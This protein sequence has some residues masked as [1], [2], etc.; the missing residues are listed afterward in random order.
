M[1]FKY[2]FLSAALALTALL[3]GC[4]SEAGIPANAVATTDSLGIFPDYRDI[5]IPQNIAPLNFM[6]TTAGED[7]VAAVRGK[8]GELV[9]SADADGKILFDSTAWH[10]LLNQNAGSDLSVT[11]YAKRDG[12]WLE[13]AP[14][15]LS[16]AEPIDPFLSYRLI[17]PGYELYRQV[18]LYQRNLTNFEEK[19]IYE[20]NRDY[21]SIDNHCVNCHNF[22]AYDTKRML[23]H[24]RAAHGG[25]IFVD[26]GKAKKFTFKVDSILGNAV[27]PAWHPTQN[28]LVFSSNIT[29][30]AFFLRNSD[31]IEVVDVSSDLVFFDA[32]R[33]T[34]ANVL[35]TGNRFETFPTWAPDGRKLYYCEADASGF[36]TLS[37][38]QKEDRVLTIYN[39]VRYNLM[40]L[41]FDEKTR[42]FGEPQLEVDCVGMNASATVPRVS[43]DGRYLLFT[44]GDYGQFH[45]WHKSSDQWVKDLETGE[46]RPLTAANSD[47]VDSY[48]SWSS[49]GRWIVFS[50][51]RIDG[52]YS[53]PF[54]AY[55][56]AHGQAHK[57]FLLPQEDPEY[58]TIL[59]KSFNVPELTRSAV[60]TTPEQ[61]QRVVY[62]D[63]SAQ[64]VQYS[65]KP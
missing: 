65:A 6:V 3:S 1:S 55:F 62:D 31:K 22:Q 11:V 4:A 54:I 28:W 18:G 10:E 8:K 57:A 43:P 42:T 48:H 44:L 38:D 5:V 47:D 12:Q 19:P 58:S 52:D 14:Y 49:N 40:S 60:T 51:R 36:D 30:Q 29:G 7:F 59:L 25:T 45:I 50:S 17:E 13:H 61:L 63:E 41:T 21:D 24:V 9:A 46:V 33:G 16:V 2:A 20:N 37:R 64:A 23:F 56:D 26:N 32:D 53:R 27:Y 35:K 34:V 39:N 15:K